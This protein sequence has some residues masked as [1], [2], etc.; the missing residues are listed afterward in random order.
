[1]AK[2][3]LT[4]VAVGAPSLGLDRRGVFGFL[5]RQVGIGQAGHRMLRDPAG[6]GSLF[7]GHPVTPV[8]PVGGLLDHRVQDQHGLVDADFMGVDAGAAG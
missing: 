6:P 8:E 2:V 5:I 4:T 7:P 3:S 1:M